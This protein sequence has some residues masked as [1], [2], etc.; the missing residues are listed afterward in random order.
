M[1]DVLLS[2]VENTL[3]LNKAESVFAK[4][5]YGISLGEIS[6]AAGVHLDKVLATYRTKENLFDV[7]SIRHLQSSMFE[8]IERVNAL[9][10]QEAVEEF[11]RDLLDWSTTRPSG[12]RHLL[13][14][15]A[16]QPRSGSSELNEV[17]NHVWD[18]I[19]SFFR[20]QLDAFRS[21]GA[22]ASDINS[23]DLSRMFLGASL[24]ILVLAQTGA[25]AQTLAGVA[26]GAILVLR[27]I[28]KK[29]A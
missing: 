21:A 26:Q 22:L 9:S 23:S 27:R 17:V 4:E 2:E 24:A 12:N 14:A 20:A 29:T 10:P 25:D 7:V 13:I 16:L 28:S 5:G 15:K 3:L 11:F 1:K 6:R 19:E 8:R 18:R